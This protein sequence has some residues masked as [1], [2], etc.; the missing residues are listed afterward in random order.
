[1]RAPRIEA[2]ASHGTGLAKGK[3]LHDAV[4]SAKDYL[5]KTLANSLAWDG[6]AA[7]NQGTL[8]W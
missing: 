8:A 3:D 4:A 7:L 6:I 5:G 2:A 1:L